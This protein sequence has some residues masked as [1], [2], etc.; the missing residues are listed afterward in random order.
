[1]PRRN[2]PSVAAEH[3]AISMAKA[4]LP[5]CTCH[6]ALPDEGKISVIASLP[7]RMEREYAVVNF[8]AEFVSTQCTSAP[9]L[10]SSLAMIGAFA[11]AIEPVMP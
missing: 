7:V 11:A 1:M 6:V 8:W 9:A 3:G 4:D 5:R 2:F 10:T